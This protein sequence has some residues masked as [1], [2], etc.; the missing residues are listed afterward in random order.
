ME[1]RFHKGQHVGWFDPEKTKI[2]LD[3]PEWNYP[4]VINFNRL[5][6]KIEVEIDGN[7]KSNVS[8]VEL[9]EQG[10]SPETPPGAEL[11]GKTYIA[12]DESWMYVWVDV[13]KKWKRIPLSDW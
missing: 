4:R 12:V 5:K 13:V 11:V 8:S 7:L 2:L 10:S 9:N 1:K 6:E 3:A